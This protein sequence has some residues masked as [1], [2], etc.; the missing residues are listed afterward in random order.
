MQIDRRSY[1]PLYVQIREQLRALF[2]APDSEGKMYTENE[3]ARQYGVNRLTVRQALNDLVHDQLVY[4]VKGVGVFVS[5]PKPIEENVSELGSFFK[6]WSLQG[7][8]VTVEIRKFER[9]A[10]PPTVASKLQIKPGTM[11]LHVDRLRYADG[12]PLAVD[13]RYI[14]DPWASAITKEKAAERTLHQI[15]MDDLGVCFHGVHMEIEAAQA[16]K[17]EARDLSIQVGAPVLLRRTIVYGE[18]K[19]PIIYGKSGYRGDHYKWT[20]YI[21]RVR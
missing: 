1:T 12:L 16:T 6:E 8:Q 14:L 3:L 20:A 4:R 2:S 19:Q 7:R 17:Q 5:R 10:A 18:E 11:V 21:S 13:H 15:L 9:I